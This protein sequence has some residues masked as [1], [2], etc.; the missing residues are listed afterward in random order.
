MLKQPA[1]TAADAHDAAGR[2]MA[3]AALLDASKHRA[4]DAHALKPHASAAPD[5]A[6]AA[7]ACGSKAF[8]DAAKRTL[9][10]AEYAQAR[11]LLPASACSCVMTRPSARSSNRCSR[12]SSRRR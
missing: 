11:V 5:G 4:A 10:K 3:S 6:T 2:G 8:L 7:P 1:R 9:D 12:R